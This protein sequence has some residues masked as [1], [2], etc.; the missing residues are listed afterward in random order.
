VP[1]IENPKLPE[2]RKIPDKP[3]PENGH[4]PK[5]IKR[6][7]ASSNPEIPREDNPYFRKLPIPHLDAA[8]PNIFE[9]GKVKIVLHPFYEMLLQSDKSFDAELWNDIKKHPEKYEG[10]KP[11]GLLY[12]EQW[13][14]REMNRTL[15]ESG[16]EGL[17]LRYWRILEMA[18]EYQAMT[19]AKNST[20]THLYILPKYHKS[21]EKDDAKHNPELYDALIDIVTYGANTSSA[22]VESEQ[23]SNGSLDGSDAALLQI[24]VPK[25]TTL[26]LSGGYIG[27]CMDNL[28]KSLKKPTE[29][30]GWQVKVNVANSTPVMFFDESHPGHV[31]DL[32]KKIQPRYTAG[33]QC[34]TMDEVLAFVKN[35]KDLNQYILEMTKRNLATQKGPAFVHYE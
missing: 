5:N 30:N 35:N 10:G 29:K 21:E 28:F 8:N 25:Q 27:K 13:I 22:F 31:T 17:S 6:P 11:P 2:N 9:K 32:P 14:V 12:C 34:S 33:Q 15:R 26:E 16:E 19:A 3:E 4:A 7:Q 18:Q 23:W 1:G 20:D 24:L